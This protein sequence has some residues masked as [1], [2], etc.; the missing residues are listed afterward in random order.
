MYLDSLMGARQGTVSAM[1][2]DD[3]IASLHHD[4]TQ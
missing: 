3:I 1:Y 4:S 2:D